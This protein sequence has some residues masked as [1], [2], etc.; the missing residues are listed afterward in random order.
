MKK[1]QRI[2]YGGIIAVLIVAMMLPM[3]SG[4]KPNGDDPV[5]DTTPVGGDG[6]VT[7]PPAGES[8]PPADETTAPSIE[9]GNFIPLVNGTEALARVIFNA[10]GGNDAISA[11]KTINAA[12]KQLTGTNLSIYSSSAAA[13][14]FNGMDILINIPG[15]PETAAALEGL[16]LGEY[17]IGV[18]SGALVIAAAD[19]SAITTAVD[20][21]CS[22]LEK[23][24]VDGQVG[25]YDQMAHK[26]VYNLPLSMVM[27]EKSAKSTQIYYNGDDSYTVTFEGVDKA[28]YDAYNTAL[29]ATGLTQY[30]A[31][32]IDGNLFA[33]Y[34]GRECVVTSIF[35]KHTNQLKIISE[36]VAVTALPSLTPDLA[37]N[38]KNVTPMVTQI[39][40]EVNGNTTNYT[41]GMSYV[42]RLDDGRFIIIDGGH[43]RAEN[44]GNLFKILRAQAPDANNIVIAAWIITHAHTDHAGMFFKH[45]QAYSKSLTVEKFIFDFPTEDEAWVGKGMHDYIVGMK[46]QIARDHANATVY[47][48]HA[49]Q[50]YLIGNAKID[51]LYSFELLCPPEINDKFNMTSIMFSIELAGQK[52]MFLGDCMIESSN[53]MVDMYGKSLD[54][55]FVQ[56]GHHGATGATTELYAEISPI[57][58]LWPIAESKY[59]AG[60]KNAAQNAYF[61]VTPDVKEIC[62]AGDN[63]Y[64]ATLEPGKDPV[65]KKYDNIASYR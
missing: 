32:E 34:T 10:N 58:V 18:Y 36:P 21:L 47:K 65:I 1:I 33:T 12:V 37:Q 52:L 22:I 15:R 38:P 3:L 6:T 49:G 57:Y 56:V 39:G 60:Y 7:T 51:I 61:R 16:S 44:A 41:N 40:L 4:C 25:V 19:D 42:I 50:Q 8:T 54:S 55:D 23:I 31:R 29:A 48:A 17:R 30:T 27:P 5:S 14:S 9:E 62:V 11:A 63:I 2:F 43:P 24:A 53:M 20:D 13:P 45:F 59:N 26:G 46:K 28:K 35:I 64:T